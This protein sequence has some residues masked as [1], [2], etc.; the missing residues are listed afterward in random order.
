MWVQLFVA[1]R[2]TFTPFPCTLLYCNE[3]LDDSLHVDYLSGIDTG[4]CP[5]EYPVQLPHLF[6]E[7]KH[8]PLPN[9]AVV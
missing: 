2:R 3:Y 6:Y 9:G 1:T 4:T 8:A 7:G 5:P